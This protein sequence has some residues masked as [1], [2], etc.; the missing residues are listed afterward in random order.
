MRCPNDNYNVCLYAT[1]CIVHGCQLRQAKEDTMYCCIKC[2]RPKIE[3]KTQ[4]LFCPTLKIESVYDEGGTPSKLDIPECRAGKC[5]HPINCTRR[6]ECL[7]VVKEKPMDQEIHHFESGASSSGHK[8]PY[9]CLTPRLIRRAA[10][11]MQKG[12]HYGKHNWKK[13]SKDKAF[14]LDR[15]NHALE[16]LMNAMQEIDSDKLMSDDDLAAVVVNCMMAMEYQANLASEQ[17]TV[18]ENI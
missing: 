13:G 10:L 7:S 6:Q 2:G 18:V 4:Y 11:R 3:H 5:I 1:K 17:Q 14:V 8:P 16:H 15:L 12:M 9:E